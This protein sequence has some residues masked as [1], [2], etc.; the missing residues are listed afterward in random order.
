MISSR[1]QTEQNDETHLSSTSHHRIP[2]QLPDHQQH[3]LDNE[4]SSTLSYSLPSIQSLQGT[5]K[6]LYATEPNF[7]LC[8][9]AST[10]FTPPL[11]LV[12]DLSSH[13]HLNFIVSSD[14]PPENENPYQQRASH[15]AGTIS[16]VDSWLHGHQGPRQIPVSASNFSKAQ[17]SLNSR[18]SEATLGS[19]KR[20]RSSDDESNK[21]SL[22][23]P[24]QPLTQ[25]NLRVLAGDLPRK[26]DTMSHKSTSTAATT[27]GLSIAILLAMN[28]ILMQGVS[29]LSTDDYRTISA[30]ARTHLARERHSPE[31]YAKADEFSALAGKYKARSEQTFIEMFFLPLT[32]HARNVR[33]EDGDG[34]DV[35][36]PLWTERPWAE[37]GL[38]IN[39]CQPFLRGS[40]PKVDTRGDKNWQKL[41]DTHERIKNPCPDRCYGLAQE[42]F[43]ME[44]FRINCSLHKYT[45]ISKGIFHPSIAIEFGLSKPIKELEGQCARGGAALVNAVRHVGLAGGEK[46]MAQGAD[47]ESLIYTF[48]MSGDI[49]YLHVHWAF[50][51][52]MDVTFHMHLMQEFSLRNGA[53]IMEMRGA[54]NNILDWTVGDRQVWIKGLLRKIA[55]KGAEVSVQNTVTLE[56]TTDDSSIVVVS[57][58]DG[59]DDEL[60]G[61]MPTSA[62][63]GTPNKKRKQDGRVP[64]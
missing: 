57:N 16:Q 6:S 45:G 34:N 59:W 3:R 31:K 7:H 36:H 40:L 49:A 27:Q 51:Q 14:F 9:Q 37:D 64:H 41:L 21:L 11:E 4:V 29:I 25:A 52:G 50:V 55:A 42:A 28:Q 24:C 62:S 54:L 38:D 8:L 13:Q 44:E 5:R 30:T 32:R 22:E 17:P 43:T 15:K 58:E 35:E 39:V 1:L 63:G 60:T 2:V 46:I 33:I 18:A 19:R 20:K 48:A 23:T 12:Q 10:D 47:R 61:Q 26:H 53:G 56:S